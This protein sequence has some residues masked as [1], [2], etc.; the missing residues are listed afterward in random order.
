MDD[1]RKPEKRAVAHVADAEAGPRAVE[2]A[3]LVASE[4]VT[5][6]RT[7]STTRH[8]REPL[9]V[10]VLDQLGEV[11]GVRLGERLEPDDVVGERRV[12]ANYAP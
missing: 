7:I 1:R 10:G 6:E 4:P 2:P 5:H 3:R 12:R 8:E 9:D 11:G